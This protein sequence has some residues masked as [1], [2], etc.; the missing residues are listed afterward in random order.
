VS[1]CLMCQVALG[2]V[3]FHDPS[4]SWLFFVRLGTPHSKAGCYGPENFSHAGNH[5][6]PRGYGAEC[7]AGDPVSIGPNIPGVKYCPPGAPSAAG[8][9]FEFAQGPPVR[10]KPPNV[11]YLALASMNG[12]NQQLQ[13]AKRT[14]SWG[15]STARSNDSDVIGSEAV[16]SPFGGVTWR[17]KCPGGGGG[18]GRGMA[19]G[20]ASNAGGL[21]NALLGLLVDRLLRQGSS[22]GCAVP[23][24]FVLQQLKGMEAQGQPLQTQV[25]V[26]ELGST[27]RPEK[28]AM[29]KQAS[30]AA[31]GSVSAR[32][33]LQHI[34]SNC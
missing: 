31:L 20:V 12:H 11:P 32:P 23:C 15:S 19:E 5:F 33:S 24:T 27:Q 28:K 21:G 13:P 10:Q 30:R 26:S 16:A 1:Q 34:K 18:T 22:H 7:H 29:T 25:Q 6:T 2:S 4:T 9:S 17:S 8:A 3:S 14:T